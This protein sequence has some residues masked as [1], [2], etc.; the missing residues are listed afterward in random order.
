MPLSARRAARIRALA[1][2]EPAAAGGKL[3]AGRACGPAAADGD[4]THRQ[5][6][7]WAWAGSTGPSR[8]ASQPSRANVSTPR[9]SLGS[10]PPL[11][12]GAA[13]GYRSM[14]DQL[15]GQLVVAWQP[16]DDCVGGTGVLRSL[17]QVGGC[18][19]AAARPF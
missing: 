7:T 10:G 8:T 16:D 2:Q 15:L 11:G 14:H 5:S 3:G 18:G 6:G 17:P 9:G 19:C 4:T 12:P 13:G 1:S